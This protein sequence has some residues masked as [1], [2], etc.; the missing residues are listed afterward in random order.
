MSIVGHALNEPCKVEKQIQIGPYVIEPGFSIHLFQDYVVDG[1]SSVFYLSIG[2]SYEILHDLF[3]MVRNRSSI[4]IQFLS[5]SLEPI[6]TPSP[7]SISQCLLFLMDGFSCVNSP[8]TQC[9]QSLIHNHIVSIRFLLQNGPIDLWKLL[10]SQDAEHVMVVNALFLAAIRSLL[11]KPCITPNSEEI[12]PQEKIVVD[13]IL[14]WSAVFAASFNM[15]CTCKVSNLVARSLISSSLSE[16]ASRKP[17]GRG[18]PSLPAE[19]APSNSRDC[20]G[21]ILIYAERTCA[22]FR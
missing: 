3:Y 17:F 5:V 7:I 20:S 15:V 11:P 8:H 4:S 22:S 13:M 10:S 21:S 2:I 14:R 6:R 18:G 19:I 9:R 1:L 12:L 16:T